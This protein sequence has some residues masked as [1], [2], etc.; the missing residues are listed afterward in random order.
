MNENCDKETRTFP[1]IWGSLSSDE[2]DDLAVKLFNAK[3]CRTRQSIW[4][5]STGRVSP[6]APL[7]R[8]T[9]A[10]TVSKF[11]GKKATPSILFPKN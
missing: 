9:V 6:N 5:W 7:I 10:K 1:E 8:E 11:T 4:E 2:R 3:C